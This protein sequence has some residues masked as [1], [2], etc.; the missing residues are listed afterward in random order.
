MASSGNQY[1]NP[2]P[3]FNNTSVYGGGGNY[4]GNS[5]GMNRGGSRG[6]YRGVNRGRFQR[7]PPGTFSRARANYYG[8]DPICKPITTSSVAESNMENEPNPDPENT[9][10]FRSILKALKE[11]LLN[12]DYEVIIKTLTLALKTQHI[13]LAHLVSLFQIDR[14]MSKLDIWP[15]LVLPNIDKKIDPLLT[16]YCSLLSVYHRVLFH[17]FDHEVTHMSYNP[18]V[19]I[20]PIQIKQAVIYFNTAAQIKT[21]S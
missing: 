19:D 7:Q 14:R 11:S 6:G 1:F 12:E 21:N 17:E 16:H 2:N 3:N 10:G 13:E 20:D 18:G 8:P 5:R 9:V 15:V 4:R